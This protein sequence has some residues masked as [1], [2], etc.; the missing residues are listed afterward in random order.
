[1]VALPPTS[2]IQY[3]HATRKPTQSPNASRLYAYGPPA[4]GARFDRR[5]NTPASSSAP[6]ALMSHPIR[7]YPPYGASDAG[8]RNTPEP[9][10]LPST[11]VVTVTRP[12][13]RFD[14][15]MC[16]P[17]SAGPPAW[18]E[19]TRA[20]GLRWCA[21]SATLSAGLRGSHDH[22]PHR[23]HA[24]RQPRIGTLRA[25][26]SAAPSYRFGARASAARVLRAGVARC[27]LRGVATSRAI[28]AA[29]FGVRGRHRD[30]AGRSRRG[31]AAGREVTARRSGIG[32]R[33]AG[34]LARNRSH[35]AAGHAGWRRRVAAG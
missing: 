21:A 10:M 19:Y 16:C 29:G 22:R 18:R 11:S 32:G 35:R 8:N 33:D 23:H 5:K 4:R 24:C 6:A 30:R 3:T 25:D 20:Q 15:L 28:R 12:I 13:C 1:M 14:T 9:I 7:L 2:A 31:H 34:R 26:P 17:F 27:G